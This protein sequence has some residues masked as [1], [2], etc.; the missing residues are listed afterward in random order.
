MKVNLR[1]FNSRKK[2]NKSKLLLQTSLPHLVSTVSQI[3]EL[4]NQ[5]QEEVT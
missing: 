3:F 5:E 2:E 4:E 1:K